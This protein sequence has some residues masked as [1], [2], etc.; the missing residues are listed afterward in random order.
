MRDLEGVSKMPEQKAACINEDKDVSHS[1][2]SN[3]CGDGEGDHEAN[4]FRM[5]VGSKY[6]EVQHRTGEVRN[7]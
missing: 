6:W 1:R 3:K 4:E 2:W 5:S 7:T